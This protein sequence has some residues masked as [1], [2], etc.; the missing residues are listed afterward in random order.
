[1]ERLNHERDPEL[2][3]L[4]GDIENNPKYY[5]ESWEISKHKYSRA[6][7]LL[8]QYYYNKE[9]FKKASEHFKLAVFIYYIFLLLLFLF[10]LF[11]LY[12]FIMLYRL[13]STVYIKKVNFY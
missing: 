7:R 6:Q 1:M 4:L 3:C 5:E 8:G 13:Q 12:C 10:L 2:F 9:D 11:F